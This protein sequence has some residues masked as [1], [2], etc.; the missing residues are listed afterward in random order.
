MM[1]LGQETSAKASRISAVWSAAVSLSKEY[2]LFKM[3][4]FQMLLS[5][6]STIISPATSAVVEC[7]AK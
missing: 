7:F 6:S 5:K 2:D 4:V 1:T 3:P